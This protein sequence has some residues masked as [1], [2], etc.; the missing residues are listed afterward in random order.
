MEEM[1]KK[2]QYIIQRKGKEGGHGKKTKKKEE[3]RIRE[4][5]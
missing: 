3:E 2:L 1:V 4:K 5:G